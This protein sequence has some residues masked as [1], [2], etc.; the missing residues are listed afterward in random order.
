MNDLWADLP[1]PH[2]VFSSF[3]PKR[4]WLP[5]SPHSPNLTPSNFFPW[6]K[7]VLKGKYFADVEEVEQKPAETLKGIKIEEFKNCFQ[8]QR[9]TSQQVYCIKWTVLWSWLKFKHVR[10]HNFLVSFLIPSFYIIL[11]NNKWLL[12]I[13]AFAILYLLSSCDF[14]FLERGKGRKTSMSERNITSISCLSHAP[15]QGP[16][17]QPRH[18]PWLGI[19]P[20]TFHSAGQ[21]SI[22]GATQPGWDANSKEGF[23]P[24]AL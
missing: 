3:R 2:W 9:K 15:N 8:Q 5:T 12:L 6:M 4:A 1:T 22:H 20:A 24:L 23:K 13:H 11:S 19:E 16:G 17:P 7:K 14:F 18:V 10:I 21:Y